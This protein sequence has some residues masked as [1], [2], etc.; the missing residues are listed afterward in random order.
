MMGNLDRADIN[1]TYSLFT[2]M[3][4]AS[5]RYKTSLE[6]MLNILLIVTS[7]IIGADVWAFIIMKDQP[8]S[9]VSHIFSYSV[10][11]I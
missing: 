6:H 2:Y 10:I 11:V 8:I 5:N 9:F 7:I 4:I 3:F 1:S